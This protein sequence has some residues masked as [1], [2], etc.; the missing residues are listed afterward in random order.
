MLGIYALGYVTGGGSR[1]AAPASS[2][3]LHPRRAAICSM[4]PPPPPLGGKG[5]EAF[6]GSL[7]QVAEE[8]AKVASDA[9]DQWVKQ[10]MPEALQNNN[11]AGATTA[12]PVSAI[13]GDA[14]AAAASRAAAPPIV[15]M[16]GASGSLAQVEE[17]A[18]SLLASEG[19]I[20]LQDEFCT[21]LTPK[22][23]TAY[24]TTDKG[25][26]I[27][28]SREDLAALVAEFS[29]GK[30]KELAAAARALA[31]YVR[32]PTPPPL[33]ARLPTNHALLRKCLAHPLACAGPC[34]PCTH[35]Y[36]TTAW[37]P[38]SPSLSRWPH[39]MCVRP[40]FCVAG[41]RP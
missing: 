26:I 35:A 40:P 1:L 37:Q 22:E 34:A 28:E 20:E 13:D 7:M 8:T 12:Q 39:P 36:Y 21:F 41:R 32:S 15:G 14:A 30:L 18:S 29:Y 2:C 31:R 23:G 19:A 10:A 16:A 17:T 24:R 25:E 11:N 3:S 38:A 33:S 9:A 4:A 5:F 27:F 6:V